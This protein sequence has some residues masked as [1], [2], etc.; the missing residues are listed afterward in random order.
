MNR[1]IIS[2]SYFALAYSANVEWS[3]F[4]AFC[5]EILFMIDVNYD[6]KLNFKEVSGESVL[7]QSV[8]SECEIK[9]SSGFLGD[10]KN[11]QD[12]LKRTELFE[13]LCLQEK[14]PDLEC[15]AKAFFLQL[16]IRDWSDRFFRMLDTTGDHVVSR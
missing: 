9:Q 14:L 5:E 10:F 12:D 13:Q 3:P 8:R 7:P 2:C 4:K 15:V 1:W 11:V 6:G 16:K